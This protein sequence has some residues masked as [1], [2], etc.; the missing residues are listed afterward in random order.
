MIVAGGLLGLLSGCLDHD[1]PP[2]D[3]EFVAMQSDFAGYRAWESH[4]IDEEGL[5]PEVG[6]RTVFISA[7]PPTGAE[8]F[9]VGTVIVKAFY[10]DS[11]ATVLDL[12]GMVKRGGGY[13]G[14]G[15]VGWEWFD[16]EP[17]ASGDP[18]I[19]WRGEEAP[20]GRG[21]ESSLGD[22]DTDEPHTGDCNACHALGWD[23]D[24]VLAEPL[25]LETR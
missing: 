18:I 21:Y 17:G 9:P 22:E 16:L 7:M 3:E 6:P 15:A 20:E 1:L 25:T 13:N 8:A 12:I 4:V 10:S 11:A 23:N 14:D 19:D 5:A 2:S 24:Y